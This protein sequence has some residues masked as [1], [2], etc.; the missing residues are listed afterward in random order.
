MRAAVFLLPPLVFVVVRRWCLGLQRADRDQLL[1]GYETGIL[2]R[3]ADCG[4]S[5]RHQ[6][7]SDEHA[8]ALSARDRDAVV[9]PPPVADDNGVIAPRSSSTLVRSRLSRWIYADNV[10]KPTHSSH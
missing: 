4:Y 10:A 5:E 2:M 6:P 8:Y 9:E 7:L 1:H 3:S